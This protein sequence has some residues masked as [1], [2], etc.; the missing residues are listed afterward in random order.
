MNTINTINQNPFKSTSLFPVRFILE[1]ELLGRDG[2]G[3]VSPCAVFRA[4][5]MPLDS[6]LDD[7]RRLLKQDFHFPLEHQVDSS[8]LAFTFP[9]SFFVLF[10][11]KHVFGR[12]FSQQ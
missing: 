7:F 10:F 8:L 1:H 5:Q 9:F 12:T 4:Y 3:L 6:K 11:L 2:I